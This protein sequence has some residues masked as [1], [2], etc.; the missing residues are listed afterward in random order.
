MNLKWLLLFHLILAA[1]RL[2][3]VKARNRRQ[4]NTIQRASGK[5]AKFFHFTPLTELQKLPKYIGSVNKI[6]EGRKGNIQEDDDDYSNWKATEQLFWITIKKDLLADLSYTG[7]K[8][9]NVHKTKEQ[10]ELN[11]T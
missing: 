9:I 4:I 2:K 1:H 3:N 6:S 5:F 7:S 11:N 10:S 8:A